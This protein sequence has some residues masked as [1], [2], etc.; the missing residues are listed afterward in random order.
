VDAVLDFVSGH[1]MQ[2]SETGHLFYN[3]VLTAEVI[4]HQMRCGKIFLN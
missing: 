3:N 1:N 2:K 4:Y